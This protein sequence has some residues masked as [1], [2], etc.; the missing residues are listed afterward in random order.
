M[1]WAASAV[2]WAACVAAWLRARHADLRLQWFVMFCK[3]SLAAAAA[4][5]VFLIPAP[6]F[7]VSLTFPIILAAILLGTGF[8]SLADWE[9]LGRMGME[10]DD[11]TTPC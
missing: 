4:M 10:N 11:S 8:L 6:W 2:Y 3:A 9:R 7:A 5:A 1:G